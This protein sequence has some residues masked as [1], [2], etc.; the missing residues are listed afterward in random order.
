MTDI[1]EYIMGDEL[2]EWYCYNYDTDMLE[3]MIGFLNKLGNTKDDIIKIF[4][5][6]NLFAEA[7]YGYIAIID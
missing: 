3:E 1:L 2:Q 4:A 5:D 7:W 6:D